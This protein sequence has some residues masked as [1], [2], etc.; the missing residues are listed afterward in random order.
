MTA[1]SHQRKKKNW[2]LSYKPPASPKHLSQARPKKSESQPKWTLIG[3]RFLT[4]PPYAMDTSND[5]AAT[6]FLSIDPLAPADL[7]L[8]DELGSNKDQLPKKRSA[9]VSLDPKL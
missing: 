1:R 9:A 4:R 2:M 8:R 5:N 7:A 6:N 3:S